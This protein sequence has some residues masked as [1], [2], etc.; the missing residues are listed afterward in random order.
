[1][2][3]SEDD[4]ADVME[5]LGSKLDDLGG[6]VLERNGRGVVAQLGSHHIPGMPP[7]VL[8]PVADL[9]KG[10]PVSRISVMFDDTAADELE[11]RMA[12][13][14]AMALS[15]RF[16][17]VMDDHAGTTEVIRPPGAVGGP[18]GSLVR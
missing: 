18:Q 5:H 1:M 6:W 4:L 13:A 17:I 8:R 15:E 9:L 11:F 3:I 10:R 2:V 14:V 16:P 7:E 12:K